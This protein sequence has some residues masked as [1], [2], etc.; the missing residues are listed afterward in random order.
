MHFEHAGWVR[1][2]PTPPDLRARPEP[3]FSLA[4]QLSQ[5]GSAL[6]LWWYQSVL[7]FDRSD[8]IHAAKRAWLAWQSAKTDH[9]TRPSS[10]VSLLAWLREATDWRAIA[11]L[12]ACAGGGIL[13]ARRLARRASGA[14]L[15]ADYATALRLLARRGLVR[16]AQQTARDFVAA[17]AATHPGTAARA[18]ERLTQRYLAQRF[19][20]RPFAPARQ[21]LRALRTAL[22]S[23]HRV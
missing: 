4:R 22:R 9:A 13:L 8:Q 7:G 15:P 5:L 10:G 6:E 1:Y 23:R 21:E 2:D 20:G 11:A 12:L 19:G 18:F 3:A 17:V 16:S 14:Q